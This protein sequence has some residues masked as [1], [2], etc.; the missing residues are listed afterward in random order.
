MDDIERRSAKRSRFD[1]TEPEPRRSRFDRRSRS[2]PPRKPDSGRDRDRSPLS[3]PRDAP[4]D[5]KSPPV[6]PAAAAAAAAA[7]INAQL[8]ARKGI[9]HVDV[10]PVRSSSVT[11]NNASPAPGAAP[12]SGEVYISDGDYIK[13]IEVNDLRNRYLLTKGSTQKM[14]KEETGADVTTR[15]NYYPDKNMATPARKWPEEKIPIN[16]ESVPGFNLRA[17]VVGHGGAYVKHIQQETTCRV[18]IKGR[19]SGYMEASTGRESDED[20]GPDPEKVQKAKELCEDLLANVREQYEEFKSRPPRNYGGGG[21]GGGYGGR[22]GGDSYQG[23]NRDSH[24]QNSSH[25]YSNSPA[26]GA[27]ASATPPTS[28]GTPT[29]AA[30]YAAQYAQYYGTADPYAA[31]GGYQAYVQMYQQWAAAQAGQAGQASAAPGAPG[32]PGASAS[33]P[34]PPPSEAAPPPPPPSAAPPPPP[35]SGPPGA[36]GYSAVGHRVLQLPILQLSNSTPLCH[37]ASPWSPTM[38]HQRYPS[39]DAVKEPHSVSLKVLRLSR[40]SL[41]AQ[42][43]FQP[44]F[45][46]PFD[47]PISHQPPI[48]ASLAY[49]SN[50]LNDVPTNPTPFVLSPILNLPPSFGSAYVGE[51]FSCTLCA[52]HDIPDDNPA[53]LAAKTIRDVRIEAEM[54]TPSSATALTLPLTP[55]SP[56]TP[57]TTPG[58]TTT[59]TTETGPGTDLSPHQTLQKILSFDLKEEGNHVL[60]VTVSYY[61][62]SELSGRTRTFRKLY[63]FVCKPSLIV[64]TKPGAL[65]PADPASGRRR[66]VLEAQLENCGKE[67]LM[68]EK[69][70]LELERGLGYEDCN[71]ES[72][73]GGG[74]GGNGGVGRMRPVLLPGETEQVCF[75]IE[76]DAAGAVEEVDGRVAFGILQIGWRSEMGNRGFLSTGKLGTRFVKP[77]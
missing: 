2:P 60:A 23:Y 22:G 7:R 32:A 47:G 10:P 42:Y 40:P 55:P 34:P 38:S 21:G 20:M 56:P 50:G 76:E 48:P 31:Y 67:G 62:A 77:R 12:I 52:N 14:I 6:D 25:S 70:G 59:A 8:Q 26:P 33:P 11:S 74:T 36:T 63:Q 57:T 39:H 41:V 66:W 13:D 69:V 71:W 17:Q 24:H 27:G 51:T 68:L 19:G 16:L 46:S 5:T 53:A 54:K 72:G 28:T 45:S 44:P 30:D 9:Q 18:Q 1:Q 75:V 43:P 64:R 65:P 4:T 35:P 29:S 58:D 15:G 61:E 73:G 49:S 3:R 37:G